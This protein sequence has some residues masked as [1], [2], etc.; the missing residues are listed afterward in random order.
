V[1]GLAEDAQRA[2]RALGRSLARPAPPTIL[3][4]PISP[5]RHLGMAGRPLDDLKRIKRRFHTT[6]NDVVLAAS[7]GGVRRFMQERGERPCRLKTMVPVSLR[8]TG[9]AGDLGNRISFVFMDLPCDEPDPVRRLLDIHVAMSDRK[10]AGEPQGGDKV[11][12]A[13]GFAPHAIQALV[14]R[15]IASPLTFNL[16][17]SN[18]PG[19]Q[20]PLYML[21]CELREAYPVVPISDRHAVS[22]GITTINQGAFF[23]VYADRETLPEAEL[24]AHS[25]DESI[26]ELL[27][28]SA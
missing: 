21:G 13:V 16:T 26:E 12:R 25:I 10:A 5:L 15:L 3:N 20:V 9:E 18:I 28:R 8:D 14:S 22:I 7:S 17:I 11:L 23:G 6:V 4:R 24:L 2:A 1:L 27:E 19:P